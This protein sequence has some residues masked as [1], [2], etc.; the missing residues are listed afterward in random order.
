[1]EVFLRTWYENDEEALKDLD[2]GNYTLKDG[3][4]LVIPQLWEQVLSH[5]ANIEFSRTEPNITPPADGSASPAESVK[6]EANEILGT[7]YENRLQYTVKYYRQTVYDSDPEFETSSEYDEPVEFEMETLH[8][9][10]PAL[11]EIQQVTASR[12]A[13]PH[14]KK[15]GRDGK[16]TRLRPNDRIGKTKLKINSLFLLNVIRSVV[17]YSAGSSEKGEEGLND[18]VFHYPYQDL[19]LHLDAMKDYTTQTTG[20]RTRHS[21]TFNKNYD[22]HLN[23]LQEYLER[24][25]GVMLKESRAKWA[26]PRPATS[27]ASIWLLLK[28]GTDVYVREPDGSLNAYVVDK[29][30]G[31]VG[32]RNGR[33]TSAS[34]VIAVWRFVLG[35]RTIR[36]WLRDIEISPFDNDREI[37]SLPVFP[38]RFQDD[39]DGGATK[40]RL[41]QR[42]RKYFAYSKR[43]N[44]LQYTG[45]GLK[46][47]KSV[48]LC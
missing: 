47:G 3:H 16:K 12:Y 15:G 13:S 17:T 8:A 22:E 7:E 38:V 6:P 34:Y 29:V 39:Y 26:K 45:D 10:L 41:I 31:G 2:Q 30:E 18:G 4:D 14:R 11:E 37:L 36:P 44:F 27:F 32:A 42:G 46:G 1:M 40:A 33:K 24:Q 5:G 28:P 23:L 20:L 35:V 43:P 19:Y 9:K 21:S 48:S 25:P